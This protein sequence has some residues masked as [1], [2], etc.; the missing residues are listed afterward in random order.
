MKLHEI[1]KDLTYN[2][3][4]AILFDDETLD[5]KKKYIKTLFDIVIL[6]FPKCR[7]FS[8]DCF[9]LNYYK[10]LTFSLDK[11]DLKNGTNCYSDPD[12][13]KE[14][15][16]IIIN[17]TELTDIDIDFYDIINNLLNII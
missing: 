16:Y 6:Y 3:K 9:N 17:F 7:N 2:D 1:L 10:K 8:L 13:Y 15:N 14:R 11:Q 12:Y 5:N 4:I